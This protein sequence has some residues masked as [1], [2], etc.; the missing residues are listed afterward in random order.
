MKQKLPN[1]VHD[2]ILRWGEGATHW[3]LNRTE[4]QI[5]ALLLMSTVPLDAD[6]ISEYLGVARSNASTSLHELLNWGIVRTVHLKE[7]RKEHYE[8]IKDIWAMFRSVVDE[9]KRREIDPVLRML[10]E[11]AQQ[12]AAD[13][14]SDPANVKTMKKLEEFFETTSTWYEQMRLLPLPAIQTFLKLGNKA[15]KLI[16]KM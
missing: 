9:Q 6:E 10:R 7:K 13:K 3:G 12:M 5:H 16:S 8:A 2:F 1:I 11:T 14:S 15:A 4:A